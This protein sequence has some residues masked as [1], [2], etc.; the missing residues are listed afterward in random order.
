MSIRD[1]A[2]MHGVSP[3]TIS[4]VRAGVYGQPKGPQT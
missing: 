3:R 2:T 1:V 4:R